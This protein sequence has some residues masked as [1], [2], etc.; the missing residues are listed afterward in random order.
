MHLYRPTDTGVVGRAQY[1]SMLPHQF[2]T[3]QHNHELNHMLLK[4]LVL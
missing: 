2:V 3:A 4:Q 1:Q